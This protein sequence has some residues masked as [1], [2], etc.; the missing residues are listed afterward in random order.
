MVFQARCIAGGMGGAASCKV[1]ERAAEA[2]Q[3]ILTSVKGDGLGYSIAG[4][5][6]VLE[7]LSVTQRQDAVKEARR[8]AGKT[9]GAVSARAAHRWDFLQRMEKRTRWDIA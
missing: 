4:G 3:I 7:P 6:N 9:G 5:L 1:C 8:K 2:L